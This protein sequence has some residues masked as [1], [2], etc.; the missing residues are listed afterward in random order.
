NPSLKPYLK[1]ILGRSEL[2]IGKSGC[3]IEAHSAPYEK[4][5]LASLQAG[6]R[7]LPELRL[8]KEAFLAFRGKKVLRDPLRFRVK[9][10][11]SAVGIRKNG[12]IVFLFLEKGDVFQLREEM[13]ALGCSEAMALDGGSSSALAA[14]KR[15][16]GASSVRCALL[17]KKRK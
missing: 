5:F 14:G 6:P 1:G 3:R 10:R 16:F 17:L 4:D 11:R 9:I 2:R 15:F 12:E 13:R 7:L 8:E